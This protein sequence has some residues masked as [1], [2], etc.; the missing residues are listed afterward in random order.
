[1]L[2]AFAIPTL[3]FRAIFK[4]EVIDIYLSFFLT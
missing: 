4:M 1:M 3:I 2:M